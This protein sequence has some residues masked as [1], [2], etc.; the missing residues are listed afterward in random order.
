MNSKD[1]DGRRK[2]KL[3]VLKSHTLILPPSYFRLAL[4][5]V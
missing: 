4:G 5:G 2:E 1:E 3:L